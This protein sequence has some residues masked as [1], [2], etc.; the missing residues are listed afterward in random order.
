M[1]TAQE[2]LKL[3]HEGARREADPTHRKLYALAFMTLLPLAKFFDLAQDSA[4]PQEEPEHE[5]SQGS[6]DGD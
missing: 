4:I 2:S 5:Q 6:S 1:M 3:L